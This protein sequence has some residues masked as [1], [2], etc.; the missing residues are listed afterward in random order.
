MKAKNSII[1]IF[2][3]LISS[4]TKTEKMKLYALYTPSHTVLKND[5]FIPSIQDDFD[6]IIEFHEQ[7]CPSA[8]FMQGG[9]TKTTIKKVQ[10]IIH[11]IQENWGKIF[12]FSDVDIQFF[13]HIQDH[14][15]RLMENKEKRRPRVME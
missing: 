6:L 1:L 4:N 12:I 11:A 5:W 8:T 14:I 7:T 10:L 2:F 9:W 13:A 3:L 15:E